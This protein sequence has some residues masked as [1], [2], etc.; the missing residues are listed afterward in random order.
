VTGLG[1]CDF[2]HTLGDAYPY[3]NHLEQAQL[4]LTRAPRP[5]PKMTLNPP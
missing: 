3:R 2:V 5:L 1:A 4:Q